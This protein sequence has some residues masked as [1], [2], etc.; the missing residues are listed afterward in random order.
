MIMKNLL[1]RIIPKSKLNQRKLNVELYTVDDLIKIDKEFYKEFSEYLRKIEP[2]SEAI[3][4]M[5]KGVVKTYHDLWRGIKTDVGER[6]KVC[7]SLDGINIYNILSE[8]EI[9]KE[10]Y[11]LLLRVM[12]INDIAINVTDDLVDNLKSNPKREDLIGSLTYDVLMSHLA[13]QLIFDFLSKQKNIVKLLK[14]YGIIN[15]AKD[16]MYQSLLILPLIPLEEEKV[17]KE[18]VSNKLS[19]EE[20]VEKLI[21]L[22]MTRGEDIKFF[23]Y[24][25]LTFANYPYTNEVVKAAIIFRALQLLY[26]DKKDLKWDLYHKT[27]SPLVS[28]YSINIDDKSREEIINTIE[29]RLRYMLESRLEK[30]SKKIGRERIEILRNYLY[31]RIR[32]N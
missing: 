3:I 24:L 13:Y 27:P 25:P 29:E 19:K 1:E 15:R 6:K 21:N 22:Y 28:L 12:L 23:V 14:F 30:L 9:P 2:R 11:K 8:K 26:K 10:I 20:I 17:Y 4:E 31:Q 5:I 7:R 32:E 16:F 18:I